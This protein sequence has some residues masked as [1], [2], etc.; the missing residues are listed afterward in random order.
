MDVTQ[1]KSGASLA[2]GIEGEA[3][4]AE[5][6]V[7]ATQAPSGRALPYGP[8]MTPLLKPLHRAFLIV[9]S[10]FS[11]ALERG[12]GALFSNPMTGYLMVLRTRG[13]RTRLIRAAPLGYVVL[14]GA[15]YC[16]AGFGETT[17]WYRNVLADPWVEVVL[18]GRTLSGKAVPV[19]TPDEWIRAYRALIASLG[20]VGRL[21]VG[22]V[23]GLDDAELLARHG[24]V[25]LVR[26]T[27]SAFVPGPLDHG[28]R[29]WLAPWGASA[30][31]AIVLATRRRRARRR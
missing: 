15:I 23:R 14:D 3:G 26:I 5:T 21:T 7:P 17:A 31:L 11:P 29:F 18:P 24:G 20:V 1:R 6:D 16:C 2:A 9:N 8:T 25:P 4:A 30:V 13:R 19:S 12:L 28:G 27:P 10:L 22:D